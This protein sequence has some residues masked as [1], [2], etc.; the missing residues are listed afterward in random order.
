MKKILSLQLI[1]TIFFCSIASA[2]GS[3]DNK[4]ITQLDP[5]D[6]ETVELSAVED[7]SY[8]VVIDGDKPIA[9]G[10]TS[11][12]SG[13]EKFD[14]GFYHG[15]KVTL[16]INDWPVDEVMVFLEGQVE[17]TNE[18]GTSKIYGPGDMLVM[19]KGFVGIWRQLGPIKKLN[20]SYQGQ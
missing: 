16:R 13:D 2:E 8:M 12:Q 4:K 14:V 20:V 6:L 5:T 15:S 1:A 19:P 9:G 7:H 17:I 3:M 10:L 18:D 11:F